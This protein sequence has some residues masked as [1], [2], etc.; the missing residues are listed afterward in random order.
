MLI[1][2][3]SAQ[4]MNSDED[5]ELVFMKNDLGDIAICGP[6]KWFVKTPDVIEFQ[7]NVDFYKLFD[8]NKNYLGNVPHTVGDLLSG[9]GQIS[10]LSFDGTTF[11]QHGRA[12]LTVSSI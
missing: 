8:E 12:E 11:V 7:K 10:I 4:K 5:N 3:F 2:R 6:S 1:D 9:R